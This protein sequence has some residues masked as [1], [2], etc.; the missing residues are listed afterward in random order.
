MTLIV[1]IKRAES[2][3]CYTDLIWYL[4]CSVFAIHHVTVAQKEKHS[5]TIFCREEYEFVKLMLALGLLEIQPS[6]YF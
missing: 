3:S 1:T 2:L 5:R 6:S 4:I